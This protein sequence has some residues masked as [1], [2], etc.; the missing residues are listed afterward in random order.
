MQYLLQQ[1]LTD[2]ARINLLVDLSRELWSGNL[3]DSRHY[4]TEAL[5]HAQRIGYAKGRA[6]ALNAIAVTYYYQGWY[7]IALHYHTQ[8]LEARRV[9]NDSI[10]IGHSMNNIALIYMGQRKYDAALPYLY[11]AL[12][13][14]HHNNLRNSVAVAYNNIGTVFRHL[15]KLDSSIVM[16]KAAINTLQGTP[17]HAGMALSFNSLAAALEDAGK[18]GD[19]LQYYHEG[20]RLYQT[21]QH[22]KGMLN[23]EYGKAS[24]LLKLK[25]YSEALEHIHRAI[26][27]A[28]FLQARPDM[29]DCYLLLSTIEETIGNIAGALYYYKRYA[30]LK[31]SLIT[32]EIIAK[33]AEFNARYDAERKAQQIKLLTSQREREQMERHLLLI[34]AGVSLLAIVMVYWR[35]RTKRH[36]ELALRQA[37]VAL[38]EKNNLLSQARATAESLLLNIYPHTI[39]ER[40]QAGEHRIAEQ[41][42]DV[43]VLFADLVNFTGLAAYLSPNELVSMLDDIFSTFDALVE[44]YHLEKIK[45]IGDAYMVVCGVPEP[46]PQHCLNVALCALDMLHVIEC[47]QPYPDVQ[48][49]SPLQI[50]IGMHTGSVVAGVIGKKKFSYDLWGDTV[51]IASRL[52]SHGQPGAIHCSEQ[53]YEI[54]SDSCIFEKRGL[55]TL[56]GNI[57]INT[58]FLRAYKVSSSL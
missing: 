16:H 29:R 52:E 56:K 49:F 9:L 2:T 53:V 43:T 4:A 6:N 37:N 55:I 15:G 25:R 38:Q 11:E 51:N 1:S 24:V 3:I 7:E 31:D 41:F 45:T 13:I 44:R 57:T 34:V 17:S 26:T 28:E 20:F 50:R 18:L 8:A 19:A 54:L 12:R 23:S 14:Y 21:A 39:A 42:H 32:E 35:Y 5:T 58:Y 27:M 10:G 47:Y 33:A 46:H 36:S 40:I 48:R 22:Q 30:Q